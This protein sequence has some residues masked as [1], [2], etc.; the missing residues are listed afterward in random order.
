MT[1]KKQAE[2]AT[3]AL[4]T[5]LADV[6]LIDT[7]TCAAAGDMSVSWWHAIRSVVRCKWCCTFPCG[8]EKAAKSLIDLAA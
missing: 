3:L 2:G 6:A 1:T 5:D 4:P 8:H 7:T